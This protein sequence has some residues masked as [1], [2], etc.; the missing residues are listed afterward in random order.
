VEL[1]MIVVWHDPEEASAQVYD[2][3][4]SGQMLSGG[5]SPVGEGAGERLLN[6]RRMGFGNED[7]LYIPIYVEQG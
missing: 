6:P 1:L 3:S 5:M 4:E 2:W 7:P